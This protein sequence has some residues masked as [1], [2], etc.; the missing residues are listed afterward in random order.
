MDLTEDD[1]W[2]IVDLTQMAS[3]GDIRRQVT[4]LVA[5]LKTRPLGEVVQFGSWVRRKMKAA[6]LPYVLVAADW[7]YRAHDMGPISGDGWEY[8]RGW[9]LARGRAGYGAALSDPDLIA[10]LFTDLED[11]LGGEEI[12]YAGIYA[13]NAATGGEPDL[14][15]GPYAY[16]PAGG[17]PD[18]PDE[19]YDASLI[20]S[21]PAAVPEAEWSREKLIARFP[22]LHRRF[23]EPIWV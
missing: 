7:V 15:V 9:L 17:A 21:W 18:P 2:R 11:F 5:H 19:L 6:T 3:P 8:F 12:E 10:D 4:L 23:G 16:R 20:E 14:S 22:R 13:Y 1:C